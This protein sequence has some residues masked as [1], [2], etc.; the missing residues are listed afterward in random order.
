[1]SRKGN[2]PLH[3][4]AFRGHTDVMR[5]LLTHGADESYKNSLGM[6]A[7]DLLEAHQSAEKCTKLYYDERR[8]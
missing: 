2:T 5:Q 7:A 8:F 6:T 4:A 1:M 3:S